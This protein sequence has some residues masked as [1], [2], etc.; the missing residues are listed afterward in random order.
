MRFALI[1]ATLA[2]PGRAV[3]GPKAKAG[4][5]AHSPPACGVKILPL[6]EGNTWTYENT[7]APAP[8]EDAIKRIAP[9]PMKTVVIT[10]KSVDAKKG[11]DTVVTLE[12]KFSRE[13]QN[14]KDPKKPIV[15]ERTITTTI[16]CNPK[17]FVISPDSFFFAG[18][19]G[20]YLGIKIDSIDHPKPTN[21]NSWVLPKGT[22]GVD[23]WREELTMHWTGVPTEGSEAKLGSGKLELERS[24]QPA[25]PEPVTT[26]FG[27]FTAEKLSLLT[28][29]RVTLDTPMAPPQDGKPAELPANWYT[30]QWL[31]PDVGLVQSLNSYAHMYQLVSATLK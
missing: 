6:V 30:T 2:L 17:K 21:A 28:T 26:K 5:P 22:V 14:P 18:E 15:D 8:P 23:P 16:T 12:E 24:Y 13:L 20:G 31:A 25:Q 29:G 3:A 11:A 1:A 10:V 19:P 7:A 27:S 9:E 4:T